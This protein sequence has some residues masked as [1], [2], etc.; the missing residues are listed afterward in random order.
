[1]NDC[2]RYQLDEAQGNDFPVEGCFKGV[3][4]AMLH[5]CG[6]N[7]SILTQ[8]SN[9]GGRPLL[10]GTPSSNLGGFDGGLEIGYYGSFGV[11]LFDKLSQRLQRAKDAADTGDVM[12]S[13]LKIGSFVVQ[14]QPV[15]FRAGGVKYKFCFVYHGLRF[16]VHGNAQGDV[17]PVRV[18]I[19]AIPLMKYG[20]VRVYKVILAILFEMGFQ[21][22]RELVSRA[23]FQVMS[24]EFTVGDFF[25]ACSRNRAVTLARGKLSAVC[26]L[27]TGD[28]ESVTVVSRTAELCVYDKVA[29]LVQQKDKGY[30]DA[31]I[32]RY[33]P[34][35][36]LPPVLTRVEFRVRGESLRSFGV[37]T[38][39]DLI[40]KSRGLLA[41]YSNDWFRVLH[42]PKVAGMGKRQAVSQLW[43]NVQ[44]AFHK[45]F[46]KFGLSS[47]QRV[48]ADRRPPDVSRLVKVAFGC[49]ARAVV[50]TADNFV[51]SVKNFDSLLMDFLDSSRSDCLQRVRILASDLAVSQDFYN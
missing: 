42:R 45:V 9:E 6:K 35:G 51:D 17:Q 33:F 46:S 24:T 4:N 38:V 39:C 1:M 34:D 5:F 23:D 30:F 41:W 48:K 18:K 27:L 25:A 43:K 19:G 28:I 12:K 8:K 20:L 40:E 16:M 11:Q 49:L 7:R 37:Y 2:S 13:Y 47:V 36:V 3:P 26:S 10:T 29:E 14:V 50:Y 15:G 44:A 22:E 31:F 32:R 21:V